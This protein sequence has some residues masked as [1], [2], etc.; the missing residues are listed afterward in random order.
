[1][2]NRQEQI[3]K[4]KN[5]LAGENIVDWKS[6]TRK[7]EIDKSNP[8]SLSNI[9]KYTESSLDQIMNNMF[10]VNSDAELR[11]E[12]LKDLAKHSEKGKDLFTY[13]ALKSA[14]LEM[15]YQSKEFCSKVKM[16]EIEFEE[17][18]QQTIDKIDDIIV[19]MNTERYEEA[20]RLLADEKGFEEL[21]QLQI[22]YHKVIEVLSIEGAIEDRKKLQSNTVNLLSLLHPEEKN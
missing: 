10:K 7:I 21:R 2:T 15:K 20:E 14:L 13:R 12:F 18:I 11:R 9:D 16:T 5:K 22:E 1:M 8:L 4:L 19:E 3:D 17:S 6:I